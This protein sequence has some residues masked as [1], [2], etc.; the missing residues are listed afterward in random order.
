MPS[1]HF[2]K[3]YRNISWDDI[4]YLTQAMKNQGCKPLLYKVIAEVIL[5]KDEFG[6]LSKSI[7]KPNS[8]YLEHVN[9]SMPSE[10]G[11]WN[12]ISVKQSSTSIELLLYTAGRTFPLYLALNQ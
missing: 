12:C 11:I 3:V 4:V 1:A 10:K 6:Q 5:T 9:R 2:V 7:S 8:H